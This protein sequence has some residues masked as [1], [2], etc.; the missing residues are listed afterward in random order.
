MTS[1]STFP[2]ADHDQLAV[3][4][5]AAGDAEGAELGRARQLVGDCP[6]CA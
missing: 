6:E 4:A 3:A 1:R 2:H 5:Y